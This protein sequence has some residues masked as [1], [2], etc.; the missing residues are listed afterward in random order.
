MGEIITL[1]LLLLILTSFFTFIY[2]VPLN[3]WSQSISAG[4][5]VSLFKIIKMRAAR[6]P[7]RI[8]VDSLISARKSGIKLSVDRLS[9]HFLA[10]GHVPSVIKALISAKNMNM[11]LSFDEAAKIDLAGVDA[12]YLASLSKPDRLFDIDSIIELVEGQKYIWV[13]INYRI[14]FNSIKIEN[15]TKAQI[16]NNRI[17]EICLDELNSFDDIEV[18]KR[19]PSL[20]SGRISQKLITNDISANVYEI[21]TTKLIEISEN[22]VREMGFEKEFDKEN[23]KIDLDNSLNLK[24]GDVGKIWLQSSNESAF[25]VINRNHCKV[26]LEPR[27][28]E[29]MKVKVKNIYEG[30]VY[31][32]IIED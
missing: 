7:A 4:V 6:V 32:D 31:V 18:L 10:G 9:D 1:L 24:V 11:A 2:Y 26:F 15:L 23:N 14:M 25:A 27:L 22:T 21:K 29:K 12:F 5:Y 13:N 8:I 16:I 17:S 30:E 3:I 19:K 20:L 28:K